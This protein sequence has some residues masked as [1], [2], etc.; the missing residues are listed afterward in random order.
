MLMINGKTVDII[1]GS[2][3]IYIYRPKLKMRVRAEPCI[4]LQ[5]II[6]ISNNER[7]Q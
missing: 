5:A 2:H 1:S 6:Y 4:R 3:K 7:A